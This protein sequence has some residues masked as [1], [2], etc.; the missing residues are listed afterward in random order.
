MSSVHVYIAFL[1]I[2]DSIESYE[3]AFRAK[4][5]PNIPF[6][7]SPLVNGKGLYSGFDLRTRKMLFGSFRVFFRHMPVK[8]HTFAYATRRFASLEKT[9]KKLV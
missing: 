7:A 2:A 4:G 9:R 6:H 5:L 1:R 3:G 8:Y